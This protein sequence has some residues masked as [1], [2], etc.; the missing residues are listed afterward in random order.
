MSQIASSEDLSNAEE[1]IKGYMEGDS[2]DKVKELIEIMLANNPAL[3]K[4]LNDSI[5]TEE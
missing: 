4:A 1:Q 3:A 5:P 2:S